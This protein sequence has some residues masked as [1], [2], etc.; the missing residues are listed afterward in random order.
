MQ[1]PS[2]AGAVALAS[3]AE[4]DAAAAALDEARW[5]WPRRGRVLTRLW[6]HA[7]DAGLVT[8]PL[9]RERTKSWD[10]WRAVHHCLETVPR[11]GLV[12][13]IGAHQS[14]V[15]WAL[16]RAGYTRLAGCDTDRRVGR[17]PG[18]HWIGYTTQDFFTADLAPKSVAALTCLSV[19]EHGM[20]PAALFERAA[21]LLRPGGRLLVTTDYWPDPVETAG[22][23]VYG[24]PWRIFSRR[25]I[26]ALLQTAHGLGLDPDGPVDL[27]AAD[28]PIL[29]SGRS[30]TFLWLAL[31]VRA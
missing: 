3:R 18:S 11:E 21:K 17:M 8:Y 9:G 16:S 22:I 25:H 12:F 1:K 6:Q 27:T 4:L 19:M 28:A 13:D 10:V 23:E 14:E 29:W 30:Y 20:E 24:R 5:S 7:A 26:E 2:R 31:A 15:L